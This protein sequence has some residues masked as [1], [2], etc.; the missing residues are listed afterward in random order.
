MGNGGKA[1]ARDR[2]VLLVVA[3]PQRLALLQLADRM[4][5][6]AR[7]PG[8]LPQ[9]AQPLDE[10]KAIT[11]AWQGLTQRVEQQADRAL[12]HVLMN[13]Q[14]PRMDRVEM[15]RRLSRWLVIGW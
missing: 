7:E 1:R 12:K 13:D 3:N 10:V 2:R 9:P 14:R 8:N 5:A 15:A 11:Q 6:Y 4:Q